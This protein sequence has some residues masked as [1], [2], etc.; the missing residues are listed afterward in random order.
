M[1]LEETKNLIKERM[2][3]G[4]S[5]M[6]IAKEFHIAR[7]TLSSLRKSFGIKNFKNIVSFTKEQLEV[8]VSNINSGNSCLSKE[9][10]LNNTNRITLNRILIERGFSFNKRQTQ[11]NPE[12]TKEF[13]LSDNQLQILIG[14]LLGDGGLSFT[15][16]NRARYFTA[17]SKK[18]NEFV[19]WKYNSLLPLSCN[20]REYSTKDGEYV[21]M[22]TFTCNELGK[23]AKDFYPQ[24]GNKIIPM[25][26]LKKLSPL[27]LAVWY[28]GDGSLNRNTG[29]ITVGKQIENVYE[30]NNTL[31]EL[32]DCNSIVKDYGR[33]YQIRF[34]NS[35]KFFNIIYP[36][37]L[38]SLRYKV[39]KTY[40]ASIDNQQ[41]SLEGNLFEG[42]STTGSLNQI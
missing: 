38:E 37:I 5:D 35:M 4:L 24:K 18:Q 34:Q 41:P 42:S 29:V 31:N 23:I 9:A 17:H 11:K 14:D 10:K 40:L 2:E 30:V 32:F 6:K 15:S 20:K 7:T 19:D 28:M 21:C 16:K 8:I 1:L 22:T 36:Y 12:W 33:Y 3:E 26:Y 13:K 27:G 39:S 25:P